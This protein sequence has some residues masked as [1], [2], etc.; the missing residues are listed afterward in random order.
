MNRPRRKKELM[1]V[2]MMFEPNRFNEQYL[3]A[4]YEEIVTIRR[5]PTRII[6]KEKHRSDQEKVARQSGG[7]L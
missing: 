1:E 5:R 4:A 7:A 6:I 3:I 2:T